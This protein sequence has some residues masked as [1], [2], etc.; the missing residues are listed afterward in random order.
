MLRFVYVRVCVG[1]AH[2]IQKILGLFTKTVSEGA[3]TPL[4]AAL[5]PDVS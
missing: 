2:C 1:Y 4:Y 3:Q 5:S